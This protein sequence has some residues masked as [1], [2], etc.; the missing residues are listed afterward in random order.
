MAKKDAKRTEPAAVEAPRISDAMA[1]AIFT[2]EAKITRLRVAMLNAKEVAKEAK[3]AYEMAQAELQ[4]LVKDAR[5]GQGQLFGATPAVKGKGMPIVA[6]TPIT[7]EAWRAVK[8]A[9]LNPPPV[10]EGT[11]KLLDGAGITTMGQLADWDVA[12]PNKGIGSIKGI[13]STAKERVSDATLAYWERNPQPAPETPDKPAKTDTPADG[14]LTPEHPEPT[15]DDLLH[16]SRGNLAGR[17]MQCFDWNVLR[18]ASLV[19]GNEPWRTKAIN[20][21]Y[22]SLS[23]AT[24]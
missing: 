24:P 2:A 11:L 8:L 23:I 20:A 15:V 6:G 16:C 17:L 4:Q 7:A 5:D 10:P 18:N 19:T 21:R 1:E 14:E 9:S 13:G 3:E 12:H 22:E